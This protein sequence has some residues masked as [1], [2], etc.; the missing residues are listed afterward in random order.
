MLFTFT[1]LA[2]PDKNKSFHLPVPVIPKSYVASVNGVSILPTVIVV[3]PP[4]SA[5]D[6][7]PRA[8][9][10]DHIGIV[11]VFVSIHKAIIHPNL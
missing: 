10:V 3:P 8:A 4:G 11:C 5:I 9:V 1:A 6:E 7:L 2:V